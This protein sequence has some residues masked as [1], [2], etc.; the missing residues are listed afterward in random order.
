MSY[1][2]IFFDADG[3]LFDYDSGQAAALAGAFDVCGLPFGADTGVV[4]SEINGEIWREYERG[5]ITQAALKTERFRR[6]F[7]RLGMAAD[8]GELSASY[9]A[10]L[11]RQ[12][13]LLEGAEEVVATLARHH[14]LLLITNGLAGV[15]R[16]RFAA[17]TIGGAFEATVISEEVGI[18][19][20][21]PAIFEIALDRVGRPPKDRVLMVGDN[22]GSDILGGARAGLDTCWYNPGGVPNGHGVEP[23]HEIRTLRELLEIV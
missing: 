21:D 22:L 18:A 6:L 17:S 3:T 5:E 8:A 11:G 10:I 12:T 14:G 23:T 4:Y 19:K 2:W 20:P 9:L 13:I 7:D 1:D 16:P 15:Q